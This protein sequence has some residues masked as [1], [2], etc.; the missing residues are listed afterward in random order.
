MLKVKNIAQIYIELQK[1]ICR[2][3]ELADGK[4]LFKEDKWDKNI[5]FGITSVI[6]NGDIIE[7]G[8]VNFSFVEGDFTFQMEKLLGEKAT[9]YS[10]T[11]I[12]SI[13]HPVN[14]HMPIIHMN[15]RYFALDNKSQWFG[16]GIDLTPHYIDV[17]ETKKF[18]LKLKNICDQYSID[19]YPNFK[20]WADD[21]YFIPHRNE[22]RGIGGIFFD[23]LKPDAKVSFE[24]LLGFTKDLCQAYPILYGNIINEKR[25]KK[26]SLIQKEWQELR[27]GRYVEFNLAYD[28]GTKFGFESNGN[29]ESILISL[30]ASAAWEYKHQVKQSSPEYDTLQLLKKGIDWVNL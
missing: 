23:R 4:A 11:G 26:Y 16:G 20:L 7:K 5:G 14:P 2:T 9:R 6:C 24:Q 3:L 28:R 27:R 18:H 21:Y 30:P 25:G 13:L 10:V 15:V 22:T 8:G 19:F 29:A 1:E 17:D 12:S